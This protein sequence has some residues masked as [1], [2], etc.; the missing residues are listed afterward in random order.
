[1]CHSLAKGQRVTTRPSLLR[2][3]LG[4]LD[5]VWVFDFATQA[6]TEAT[7]SGAPPAARYYHSCVLLEVDGAASLVAFGGANAQ[8]NFNDVAALNLATME[9]SELSPNTAVESAEGA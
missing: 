6:W 3:A 8:T 9:W 1:M 5:D 7:T 4:Y 2:P